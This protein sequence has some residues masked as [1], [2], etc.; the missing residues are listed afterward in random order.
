MRAGKRIQLLRCATAYM[1]PKAELLTLAHP[2]HQYQ[3]LFG[4]VVLVVQN[5]ESQND[6]YIYM[7][8]LVAGSSGRMPSTAEDDPNSL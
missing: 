1:I 6:L 5:E 4:V 8:L 7:V 3:F 2:Y